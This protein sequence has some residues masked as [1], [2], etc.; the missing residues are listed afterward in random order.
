MEASWHL[1]ARLEFQELL[2]EEVTQ[3]H[4][5]LGKNEKQDNKEHCMIYSTLI[6]ELALEY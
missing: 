4:E 3:K 5:V 6:T 2:K 1:W